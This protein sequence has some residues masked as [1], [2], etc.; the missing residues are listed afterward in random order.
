MGARI[1]G[2]ASAGGKKG[3]ARLRGLKIGEADRKRAAD[4][5]RELNLLA[6]SGRHPQSL[7]GGEKQRL[8][9]A[10]ALAKNPAV[11]ILDEPTSGLDGANMAAIARVMRRKAQEGIAV[12]LI[13]HDLEFLA[14]C[15]RALLMAD[16]QPDR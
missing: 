3:F 14:A 7:S 11:L 9:I 16:L 13:T 6:L 5:L 10:C 2:R 12:F 1:A 4:I 8:V 15:D